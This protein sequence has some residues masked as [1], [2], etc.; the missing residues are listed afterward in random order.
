[1]GMLLAAILAT[2]DPKLSGPQPGEKTSGF[3]VFDGGRREELDDI[4][5]LKGGPTV[6]IFFH[7]L[8]RPDADPRA[9]P[10]GHGARS[11]VDGHDRS[12][13]L[14]RR[15]GSLYRGGRRDDRAGGRPG[16]GLGERPV[17]GGRSALCGGPDSAP[18]RD[19]E[20]RFFIPP[21]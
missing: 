9:R 15:E 6:L 21:I 1:M 13:R 16:G 8:T 18:V 7:E 11:R 14:Q 4:A 12:V 5:E 20:T 10:R 3:T 2:Q 17:S 19:K